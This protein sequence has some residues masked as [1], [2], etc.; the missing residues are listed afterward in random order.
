MKGNEKFPTDLSLVQKYISSSRAFL[1]ID[2]LVDRLR[3]RKVAQVGNVGTKL[4]EESED[5]GSNFEKAKSQSRKL[6]RI[7]TLVKNTVKIDVWNSW[8][9]KLIAGRGRK[10]V[11][12][13]KD[14]RN[15]RKSW[16]IRNDY[17]RYSSNVSRPRG[18]IR[19]SK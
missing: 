18:E 10:D 6:V 19:S 14:G 11:G 4:Q 5:E 3:N 12:G 2:P 17:S 9:T 15:R 13:R 7:A 8:F 16:M 1:I